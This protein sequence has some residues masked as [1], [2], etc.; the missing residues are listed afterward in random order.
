M[1]LAAEVDA[2]EPPKLMQLAAEVRA[3]L[4]VVFGVIWSIIETGYPTMII[5][6][7]KGLRLVQEM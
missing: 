1:Q 4:H 3:I 2:I 6:K 5:I 7:P